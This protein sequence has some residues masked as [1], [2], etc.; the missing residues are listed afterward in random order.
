MNGGRDF[1]ESWEREVGKEGRD[2]VS[3]RYEDGVWSAGQ[4]CEYVR[5]KVLGDS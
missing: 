4:A 3:L 5:A 2:I 1:E